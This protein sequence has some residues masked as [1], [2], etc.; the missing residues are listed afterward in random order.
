[1]ILDVTHFR[2][3][4]RWGCG[5]V[6]VAAFITPVYYKTGAVWRWRWGGR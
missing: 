5:A 6:L 2:G 1:M 3:V 4:L